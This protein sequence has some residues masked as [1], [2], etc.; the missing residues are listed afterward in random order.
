MFA[1]RRSAVKASAT[2][3]AA[4]CLL[5]SGPVVLAD[6]AMAQDKTSTSSKPGPEKA[7]SSKVSEPSKEKATSK[8][9][10]KSAEKSSKKKTAEKQAT[11]SETPDDEV[12]RYSDGPTTNRGKGIQERMDKVT[13]AIEKDGGE[14]G[15]GFLDRK[16]GEFICNSACDESFELASLSKVF[17]AETVGFTN[18]NQPTGKIEGGEGEAPV[19]GNQDAMLR[20]DMIRYSDN[21]A[22]NQ[23]WAT[24]GGTDII[25]SAKERY[26][27]SSST[28]PNPDWGA[29]A[30]SPA[31]M[32]RFFDGVLSSEGGMSEAETDYFIRMMYSVP[33]FSYGSADQNIGLRA[34]LPDE[35]IAVKGGW[36]DPQ[37]RA[38]G[39]FMGEDNRYIVV[40]LASYVSPEDFTQ[41]I[42]DVF[43]DGHIPD[44]T[45]DDSKD[46]AAMEP[47][48]EGAETDGGLLKVV[49]GMA[50]LAV[51]V[52]IGWFLPRRKKA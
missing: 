37:I 39:G 36:Y 23:L 32:V 48:E 14:F 12:E 27:L 40:A 18:Y 52:A 43:P 3:V 21:E 15:I 16:T 20:D 33:R 6:D 5:A 44:E 31:D 24:Y 9:T 1:S 41:A 47:L 46:I 26:Q 50:L 25:A 30:S 7:S 28:Q 10:T 17:I 22:T 35:R 34:A 29:T 19:D 42:A 11:Y 8:T 4:A 38:V 13:T 45:N 51:G 2:A 49:G